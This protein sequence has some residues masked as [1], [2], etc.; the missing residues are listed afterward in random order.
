MPATHVNPAGLFLRSGF[1]VCDCSVRGGAASDFCGLQQHFTTQVPGV[2]P[3]HLFGFVAA[4][5]SVPVTVSA[6]T[7]VCGTGKPSVP[8]L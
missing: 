3:Q 7:G 8:A 1:S 4:A 5:A 6:P 2:Q